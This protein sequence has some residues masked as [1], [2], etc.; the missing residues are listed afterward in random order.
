MTN[1]QRDELLVSLSKGL[2]NLQGSLNDFRSELK[3]DINNVNQSLNAKI[4][5]TAKEL[6]QE[7]REVAENASKEIKKEIEFNNFG[8]TEM[9][10]DLFDREKA[11]ERRID[12]HDVEIRKLKEKLA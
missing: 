12:K 4:D 6:R 8:I 2:N 5:Q 1:E 3:S 9:A 7:I 11:L 10:H